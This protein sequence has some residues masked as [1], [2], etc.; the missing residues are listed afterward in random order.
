MYQIHFRFCPHRWQGTR[1]YVLTKHIV[2][3][4]PMCLL[5]FVV[6]CTIFLSVVFRGVKTDKMDDRRSTSYQR[7]RP[8]KCDQC[9][10]I[11]SDIIL[12]NVSICN[13][14][15]N[16]TDIKI[17]IL[18]FSVNYNFLA[19]RTIRETW[20]TPTY[21]K[22]LW[23]QHVFLFGQSTNISVDKQ[24]HR[25]H[26]EYGDII[27]FSFYDTYRILTYKTIMGYKW[28]SRYC[29]NANFIFKT[30][31]DVYVNIKGLLRTVNVNQAA[32]IKSVAGICTL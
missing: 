8:L 27:Q 5:L 13:K 17:L 16:V 29:S 2:T 20:L 9:L 25:E 30:D 10:S 24:L 14:N 19:R 18:I 26:L 1:S 28:A 4:L 15:T 31:D 12:N 11:E 22:S 3:I 21:D 6:I 7:N 23:V 32:L